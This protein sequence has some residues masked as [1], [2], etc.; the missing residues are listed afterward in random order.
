MQCSFFEDLSL[1]EGLKES[2]LTEHT[3]PQTKNNIDFNEQ[4]PMRGLLADAP[5]RAILV[6]I[7]ATETDWP[8]N[9][10]LDELEQLATTAGI[11][12]IDRVVQRMEHP[13]SGHFA[14][15]GRSKSWQ[16]W[17]MLRI[18]MQSFSTLN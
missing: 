7:D 14:G 3:N 17:H 1:F 16:N 13:L 15:S 9:E 5:M 8:I 11:V 12:C 2:A 6:T 10:S 18:V 4:K